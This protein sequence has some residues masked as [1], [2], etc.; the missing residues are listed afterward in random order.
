MVRPSAGTGTIR[1]GSGGRAARDRVSA[2]AGEEAMSEIR[3][4]T[5]LP[6]VRTPLT[7]RTADGLKLVG[8]LARPEGRAPAATLVFLPPPPTAGGMKDND[9]LR[10][11]SY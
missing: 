4:S 9:A 1:G 7:L 5:V 3:A 6:A 8:E 2:H 11:A 10:K